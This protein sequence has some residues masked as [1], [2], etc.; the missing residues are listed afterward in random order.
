MTRVLQLGKSEASQKAHTIASAVVVILIRWTGRGEAL[1]S[2][3]MAVKKALVFICIW[4]FCVL[5]TAATMDI[6]NRETGI[7]KIIKK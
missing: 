4:F 7:V 5:P 2:A 1:R 3:F 6:V